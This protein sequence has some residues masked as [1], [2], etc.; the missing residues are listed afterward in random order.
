MNTKSR[1]DLLHIAILLTGG[2][3]WLFNLSSFSWQISTDDALNF[4]RGFERFSVLEFRPHF[5]G[6]PGMIAGSHILAW[7]L[8]GLPSNLAI[9]A[10]SI[11]GAFCIPILLAYLC[12]V[13]SENKN[14]ATLLALITYIYPLLSGIA[15]SAL[16]DAPAIMFLLAA[17]ILACKKNYFISGLLLA[18]M[19]A[20]RPAYIVLAITAILFIFI[21]KSKPKEYIITFLYAFIPFVII[22]VVCMLFI[23]SKD[24]V[25]Y[26]SEGLR[27][28]QGHFEI[29]GNTTSTNQHQFITW[30]VQLSSKLGWPVFISL[31]VAIVSSLHHKNSNV[32]I[33]G[34]ITIAYYLVILLTQNPDN[35]RH[36]APVVFLGSLLLTVQLSQVFPVKVWGPIVIVTVLICSIP[37]FEQTIKTSP[38]NQAIEYLR[39]QLKNTNFEHN[40]HLILGTN[41]S[42]NLIRSKLRSFSVYDLYYPSHHQ[43]LMEYSVNMNVR[44]LSGM[45]LDSDKYT[46]EAIFPSRFPTE[47]NLYLYEVNKK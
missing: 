3:L 42:V 22:G 24:G 43:K 11:F 41:Y 18:F 44:R 21:Q 5:P 15:L 23:L 19:L 25:A 13:L 31:S 17:L 4:A 35:L 20:T 46:I 38:T 45:P 47:R 33:I 37:Y 32:K 39:K 27:F 28:T 30:V 36:F 10:F 34:C 1:I 40:T 16:S 29:W 2:L 12:Y 14:S 26:F 7:M 9:T 6:Y 8:G